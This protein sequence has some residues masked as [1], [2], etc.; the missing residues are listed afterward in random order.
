M[1]PQPKS[2]AQRRLEFSGPGAAS[3]GPRS[4]TRGNR[5]P[6][7][8]ALADP[9]GKYVQTLTR[10]GETGRKRKR[11]SLEGMTRSQLDDEVML[12]K[13]KATQTKDTGALRAELFHAMKLGI[14]DAK[15]WTKLGS[16]YILRKVLGLTCSPAEIRDKKSSVATLSAALSGSHS[17]PQRGSPDPEVSD[18][19]SSSG[20]APDVLNSTLDKMWR[21]ALS[22]S[23]L[24]SSVATFSNHM[25]EVDLGT[26]TE[27]W[28]QFVNFE[29]CPEY[30]GVHYPRVDLRGVHFIT[31]TVLYLRENSDVMKYD[32]SG[33][34]AATVSCHDAAHEWLGIMFLEGV[35]RLG[36]GATVAQL[37]LSKVARKGLSGSADK[38]SDPVHLAMFFSQLLQAGSRVQAKRPFV[39]G[40][41]QLVPQSSSS[42][43]PVFVLPEEIVQQVETTALALAPSGVDP[44][45]IRRAVSATASKPGMSFR[46]KQVSGW[47]LV[48]QGKLKEVEVGS[49]STFAV[50]HSAKQLQRAM[51]SLSEQ[52]L[53]SA[54]VSAAHAEFMRLGGKTMQQCLMALVSRDFTND[55]FDMSNFVEHLGG[56]PSKRDLS[57]SFGEANKARM[58]AVMCQSTETVEDDR[59]MYPWLQLTLLYIVVADVPTLDFG[60]RNALMWFVDNTTLF[61]ATGTPMS[62]V[63]RCLCKIFKHAQRSRDQTLAYPEESEDLVLQFVEPSAIA[64]AKREILNWG[65]QDHSASILMWNRYTSGASRSESKGT[66]VGHLSARKSQAEAPQWVAAPR[67]SEDQA[68]VTALANGLTG[69]GLRRIQE[70]SGSSSVKSEYPYTKIDQT[71]WKEAYGRRSVK[72]KEVMCCWFRAN[73]PGGCTN[74]DNPSKCKFNH[75]HLPSYYGNKVFSLLDVTQQ[76]TIL[77]ACKKA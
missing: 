58:S 29:C 50:V 61:S 62:L 71:L 39:P 27:G 37:K 74:Q 47:K 28:E 72:G 44:E 75:D 57:K 10:S 17:G 43:A 12:R 34:G 49:E 21:G 36:P 38:P 31:A 6:N 23:Q 60:F 59:R 48:G 22:E 26:S 3:L 7:G 5:S 64:T 45:V 40:N 70:L 69:N 35:Q 76:R 65:S 11:L 46:A 33:F 63:C 24:M 4:L 55:H 2:A 9:F 18:D 32:E 1:T 19:E 15:G 54:S 16:H 56:A 14:P 52:A 13:F 8:M 53:M 30:L 73:R 25:Q 68:R 51:L 66:P 67:M 41:T 42:S 77:E 20:D